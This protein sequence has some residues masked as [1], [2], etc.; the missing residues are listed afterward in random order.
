MACSKYEYVK[1]Y[2]E[3][4]VALHSTYIVIR[5]DVR[6]DLE[7]REEGSQNFAARMTS[8]NQMI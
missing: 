4:R 8:I 6:N 2:E 3:H 5:V 1:Q 7:D